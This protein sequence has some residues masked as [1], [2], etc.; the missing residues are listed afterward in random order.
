MS[1]VQGLSPCLQGAL[2]PGPALGAEAVA[3]H[4]AQTPARVRCVLWETACC[5]LT[6]L[7]FQPRYLLH[8]A[9]TAAPHWVASAGVLA[10]S[11][12]GTA[13]S[14]SAWPLAPLLMQISL[15]R[16]GG[17][18]ARLLGALEK[19]LWCVLKMVVSVT[20]NLNRM[21]KDQERE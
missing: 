13:R 8:P 3:D 5:G 2:W 12:C 20:Q 17:L 15:L 4:G 14:S 11:A 19:P 9:P 10:W 6:R 7:T 21:E 16:S 18:G 1:Q